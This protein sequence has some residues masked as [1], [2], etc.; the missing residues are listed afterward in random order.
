MLSFERSFR[1]HESKK[2]KI[3]GKKN[4]H[5]THELMKRNNNISAH[6][7]AQNPSSSLLAAGRW[8]KHQL[9]LCVWREQ[10]SPGAKRGSCC[11]SDD[12]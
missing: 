12:G 3:D 10:L 7:S 2:K 8:C 1:H 9:G 11:G 5:E 6:L 4:R